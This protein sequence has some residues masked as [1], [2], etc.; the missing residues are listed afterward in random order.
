MFGT[1]EAGGDELIAHE[2][3]MGPC[4]VVD[5]EEDKDVSSGGGG[6]DDLLVGSLQLHVWNHFVDTRGSTVGGRNIKIGLE[7]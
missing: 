2:G 6:G 4:V 7:N 3:S 1:Y 5:T